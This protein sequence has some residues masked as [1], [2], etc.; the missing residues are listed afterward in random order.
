MTRE[1]VPEHEHDFGDPAPGSVVYCVV[2]GCVEMRVRPRDKRRKLRPL[3]PS[4]QIQV[5]AIQMEDIAI[6]QAMT[7]IHGRERGIRRAREALGYPT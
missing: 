7:I 5:M 2:N 3:K 4:E 6:A 1:P